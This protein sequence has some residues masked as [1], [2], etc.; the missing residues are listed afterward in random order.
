MKLTKS[1]CSA[2]IG[3]LL[4]TAAFGQQAAPTRTIVRAGRLLDVRTGKIVGKTDSQGATVVD[5]PT[6]PKD[7]LATVY[8]LL[9]IDPDTTLTDR[10]GRPLPLVADGAVVTEMLA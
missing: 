9:G 3:L 7:I 6:S 8:H 4:S 5:R 1:F 10:T 2:L